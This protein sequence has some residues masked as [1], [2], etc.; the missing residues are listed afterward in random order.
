MGAVPLGLNVEGS[1]VV[2]DSPQSPQSPAPGDAPRGPVT[3]D[4]LKA[5]RRWT[6][7]A[8]IWA[9]A[10][11][12]VALIALLDSSK[13]DAQQRAEQRAGDAE[14]RAAAVDKR[15]T[16]VDRDQKAFST[17]I[18]ELESRLGALAPVTDVS[19]LQDRVGRAEENASEA[20]DR[21]GNSS[22]KVK[23]LEGRVSA[24]EK[25]P[26]DSGASDAPGNSGD[27]GNDRQP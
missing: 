6:L 22:D 4:D 14:Q 24:L 10:A 21:V 12:A 20:S 7:V 26:N 11:T 25:A 23:S 17:R 9:V 5:L 3:R 13:G 18:E 19:R 2:K 8:G 15:V 27:S 16:K 1:S